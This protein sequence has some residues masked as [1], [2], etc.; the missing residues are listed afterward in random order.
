MK[1]DLTKL[2]AAFLRRAKKSSLALIV[3]LVLLYGAT[4]FASASI[5]A[6]VFYG[7]LGACALV[8]S[9]WVVTYLKKEDY[10]AKKGK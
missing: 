5:E 7:V 9:A 3:P 1:I 2:L 10:N 4:N 8:Y 6:L